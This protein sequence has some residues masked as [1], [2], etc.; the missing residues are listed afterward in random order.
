MAPVSCVQSTHNTR[1]ENTES[2]S[3]NK[4]LDKDKTYDHC[5]LDQI[6]SDCCYKVRGE[7]APW[8]CYPHG[9]LVAN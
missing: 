4:W 1:H 7:R 5:H 8:I 9:L 6:T 3:E 2:Q